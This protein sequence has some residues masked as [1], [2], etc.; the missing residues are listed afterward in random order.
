MQP[1]TR[2]VR[3]AS[4]KTDWPPVAVPGRAQPAT[5]QALPAN[6]GAQP[7]QA[8]GSPSPG[9]LLTARA[10][11]ADSRAADAA[12]R[13][14]ATTGQLTDNGDRV[15]AVADREAVTDPG[16]PAGPVSPG[17]GIPPTEGADLVTELRSAVAR[18]VVMPS[19]E[20]LDA[21]TL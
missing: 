12:D 5:A 14:T 21:V 17:T 2:A 16:Q 20:A 9:D 4:P 7:L 1:T 13:L 15:T 8:T 10:L 3:G 19:S 6:A 18:Y 11:S